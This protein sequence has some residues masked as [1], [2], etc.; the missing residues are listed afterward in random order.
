MGSK[1]GRGVTNQRGVEACLSVRYG[2]LVGYEYAS[3]V[4]GF[5]II[6]VCDVQLTDDNERRW[7][8]KR[9]RGECDC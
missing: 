8:D 6:E 7:M 2:V 3:R 4:G 1:I 9:D 5:R